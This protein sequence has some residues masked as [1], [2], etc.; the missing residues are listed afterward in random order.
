MLLHLLNLLKHNLLRAPA[1]ALGDDLCGVVQLGNS[2]QVVLKVYEFV[3]EVEEGTACIAVDVLNVC[4]G[5]VELCI[6]VPNFVILLGQVM[7]SAFVI[8]V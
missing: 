4:G 7:H 3:A 5:H 6:I 8:L 1:F 2:A